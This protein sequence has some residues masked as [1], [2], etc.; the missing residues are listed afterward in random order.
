MKH[1][2][3]TLSHLKVHT[4]MGVE[5]DRQTHVWYL[6]GSRWWTHGRRSVT[7]IVALFATNEGAKLAE[8]QQLSSDEADRAAKKILMA[9]RSIS[10]IGP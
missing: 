8:G 6:K 3:R 4:L 10:I 1:Y 7:R 5:T 2:R 9:T